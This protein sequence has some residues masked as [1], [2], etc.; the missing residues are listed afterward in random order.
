VAQRA[1]N[2]P[3]RSD[4]RDHLAVMAEAPANT[5]VIRRCL[6]GADHALIEELDDLI[7]GRVDIGRARKRVR[8]HADL[9]IL[10]AQDHIF[11]A[12]VRQL[13]LLGVPTWL[14]VPGCF[15]AARFHS[16]TT[17]VT[18]LRLAAPRSGAPSR[19]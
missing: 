10:V 2:R 13:R 11:A 8:G 9:V 6:D 3:S 15:V 18:L 14:L 17:D 19:R 7:A 4:T 5:W 16:A 1:D 12:Q